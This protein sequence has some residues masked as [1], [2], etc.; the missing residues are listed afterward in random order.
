MDFFGACFTTDAREF[1]D[2]DLALDVELKNTSRLRD[3]TLAG[4]H[5]SSIH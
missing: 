3:R 5:T 2:E 1:A 4:V